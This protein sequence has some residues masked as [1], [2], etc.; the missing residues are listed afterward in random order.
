MFE[1]AGNNNQAPLP[2]DDGQANE[3]P[4]VSVPPAPSAPA[5]EPLEQLVDRIKKHRKDV[6]GNNLYFIIGAI[7]VLAIIGGGVYAGYQFWQAQKSGNSNVICA[8]DAKQCADGTYVSRV[9]PKCEF[10][11]CP[12]VV[13]LTSTSTEPTADW[14]IYKNEE[15]GFEVK[16]PSDLVL[17]KNTGEA[18]TSFSG[19]LTGKSYFLQFGYIS[20]NTLDTRGVNY[21]QTYPNDSRCENFSFN[22]L[23]FLID[24]NIET[25]GA[26]TQSRAEILKPEDGMITL[27]ILY[28]PNQ[29]IK[30]FFR[31]ILS[32]FKFTE[33]ADTSDWQTYKNEQ[34]G[35]EVKYPKDWTF[36]ERN[37]GG[38]NIGVRFD[39]SKIT[40]KGCDINARADV[41]DN[42]FSC[43]GNGFDINIED[44]LTRDKYI[45]NFKEGSK[46]IVSQTEDIIISGKKFTKI[47][48]AN[49]SPQY[50]IEGSGWLL[51]FESNG[52][53]D[54]TDQIILSTFKFTEPSEVTAPADSDNDGLDDIDEAKYGTDAQNPDSDGD[55]F[56]DGEEVKNGY[57]PLGEGKIQSD[58]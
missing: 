23:N 3:Q 12:E 57:N 27:S 33:P 46:L 29:D 39:S 56:L 13:P 1:N 40:Q 38:S 58:N 11:A 18:Y 28:S 4:V 55:G 14:Q 26:F 25:E 51:I 16:F 20:Q 44:G 32:T 24:W 34:Y 30:S 7:V 2:P 47:I 10:A 37:T 48:F 36:S 19:K 5:Q 8:Q 31:Q 17:Q 15:Y 42:P 52:A 22:N 49:Y 9:A 50:I 41:G 6:G 21:C 53:Y 45:D 35:F 54:R 43:P